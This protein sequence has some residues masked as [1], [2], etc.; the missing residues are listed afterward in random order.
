MKGE[1]AADLK[2]GDKI[3]VTG[4]LTRYYKAATE[5]KPELDKIEFN[6][7]CTFVLV[8]EEGGDDTTGDDTTGDD[9]QVPETSDITM[10]AIVIVAALSATTLA[11]LVI[12]KKKLF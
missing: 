1:G 7:G 12:G 8:T 2:V 11:V 3:A 5:D 9:T 4:Q 10:F 6:S